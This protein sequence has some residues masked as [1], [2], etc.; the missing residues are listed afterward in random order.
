MIHAKYVKKTFFA[1]EE[2]KSLQKKD[3]GDMEII[4]TYL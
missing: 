1:T 2:N 3:I 4:L